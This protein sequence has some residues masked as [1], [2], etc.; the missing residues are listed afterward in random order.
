[1]STTELTVFD[2]VDY[3]FAE[4]EFIY[5][6]VGKPPVVIKKS[7]PP[8]VNPKAV[9]PLLERVYE[10]VQLKDA[11]GD[12]WCGVEPIRESINVYLTQQAKWASDH[13]RKRNA[14][15]FPTMYTYDSRGR[16]FH[17]GPGSDAG[18]LRTYFDEKGKRVQF[19][20]EL[21][22]S[23][24]TEWHPEWAQADIAKDGI[25]VNEP[26]SRFECPV[27]QRA[28]SYRPDS[29]ASKT[30]ARARMSKHLKNAKDEVQAHREVYLAEFGQKDA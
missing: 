4:N 22:P 7:L 9:M 23:G 13:S 6:Q 2:P 29:Q 11:D 30:A 18:K 12:V 19:A 5:A 28:E 21:V 10:L 8:G 15:R 20:V 26:A 25:V 1:M 3:S 16:G 17:Y 14:P 24:V 27:C